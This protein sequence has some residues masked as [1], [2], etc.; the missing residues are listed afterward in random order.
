MRQ[1][2]HGSKAQKK[3][4]GFV[5]GTLSQAGGRGRSTL[6]AYLEVQD[7]GC[8]WLYVGLRPLDLGTYN[9]LIEVKKP[10]LL[11]RYPKY[12]NEPLSKEPFVKKDGN[13]E[14]TTS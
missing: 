11:S 2:Q 8:N 6:K 1:Q 5:T 10:W 4:H 13:D 12:P 7:T 14:T 9:P 3:R